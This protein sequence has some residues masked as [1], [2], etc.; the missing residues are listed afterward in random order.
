MDATTYVRLREKTDAKGAPL[1][2]I[3]TAPNSVSVSRAVFDPETGVRAASDTV[4]EVFPK[5]LEQEKAFLAARIADI[6]AFLADLSK[7]GALR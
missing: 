5:D 2:R 7:A 6:D 4:E 1:V 3:L